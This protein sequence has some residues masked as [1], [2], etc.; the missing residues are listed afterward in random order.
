MNGYQKLRE[1]ADRGKIN[2]SDLIVMG[3]SNDPY[4]VGTDNQVRFAEWFARYWNDP[5]WNVE[6]KH[7]RGLHYRLQSFG[8]IKLPRKVKITD[9][10]SNG[11]VVRT[12]YTG[13]YLNKLGCW[14]F[15]TEPA[16]HARILG[17][18]DPHE[19]VDRRNASVYWHASGLHDDGFEHEFSDGMWTIHK[20]NPHV[21]GSSMHM[22]SLDITGHGYQSGM[23]KYLLVL[24][25]EKSTMNEI[26]KP[27][28]SEFNVIFVEGKGY[29]S[30]TRILELLR[31]AEQTGKPVRI[32]YLSDYDLAGKCMPLSTS[33]QLQ[34]WTDVEFD[35][36][37]VKLTQ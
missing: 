11:N 13:V 4:Y 1:I 36:V 27:I 12:Y 24:F 7:M 2:A 26:I 19:F 3:S 31:H 6:H 14:K 25:V 32:F 10:D 18:V 29:T 22:P 15:L 17:L 5:E 23:Q 28:C 9:K 30:I 20:I 21:Y 35:D 33:R 34:W 8:N 37:D 16:K